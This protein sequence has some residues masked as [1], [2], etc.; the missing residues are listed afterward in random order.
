MKRRGNP[1]VG[2]I[3]IA[4]VEKIYPHS[5][6]VYL[7]EYDKTGFV[8]ISEIT[9]GWIKDIR[10]HIK[11]GQNVV[12]KVVSMYDNK[13][14]VSLKKVS[15]DQ[16]KDKVKEEKTVIASPEGAKQ[17]HIFGI[18]SSAFGLLA[19][20]IIFFLVNPIFGGQ[21]AMSKNVL[22]VVAKDGFRDEELIEPQI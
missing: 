21:D 9:S 2:E 14:N 16:K 20:T 10:K 6:A 3:V 7:N 8:H 22:M 12:V 19:M 5:A 11:E 17:S 18:A 15:P 13:I 1:V 4:R